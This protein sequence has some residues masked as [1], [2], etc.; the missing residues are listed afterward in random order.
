MFFY[1]SFLEFDG[2][3]ILSVLAFDSKAVE[4]LLHERNEKYFSEEF[5][6][7]Y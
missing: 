2:A 6:V 5:P 4:S 3:N 7:I 1:K